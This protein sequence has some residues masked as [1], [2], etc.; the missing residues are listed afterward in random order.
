MR[1]D[2]V[3][4]RH[5]KAVDADALGTKDHARIL[6]H[7]GQRQS[8]G[9]GVQL[10]QAKSLPTLALVSDAARTKETWAGVTAGAGT[11]L[12]DTAVEHHRL[13]YT[14]SVS[15]LKSLI[16]PVDAARHTV[17]AM[18]GHNPG[19][20][21]LACDL[22]SRD[23]RFSPADCM[24]LSIEA[25]SWAEAIGSEGAWELVASLSPE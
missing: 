1:L 9:L 17:V 4:V 16:E 21:E 18:V 2:L 25:E 24:V 7:R 6:T 20:S 15:D 8:L 11:A 23:L 10:V 13:I 19:I 12:R 3:L 5:G 22:T 14:G